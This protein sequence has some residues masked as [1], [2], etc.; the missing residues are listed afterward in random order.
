[1]S[2]PA[3]RSSEKRACRSHGTTDL[4]N[5]K[6]REHAIAPGDRP[7]EATG[8]RG[9]I[10]LSCTGRH[11]AF[12]R[13]AA[14]ARRLGRAAALPAEAR[15]RAGT[16]RAAGSWARTAKAIFGAGRLRRIGARDARVF[17]TCL[18]SLF[19]PTRCPGSTWLA[20]VA[21]DTTDPHSRTGSGR[22]LR[23]VGGPH[24]FKQ[25]TQQCCLF[26]RRTGVEC[27]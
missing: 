17:S 22:L 23:Q 4:R 10:T 15:R 27:F 14:R 24:A 3:R 5:A 1:M 6:S 2:E 18:L 25:H 9:Q 21:R 12:I 26:G 19:L 7:R 20:L 16:T 13:T 11:S 8:S